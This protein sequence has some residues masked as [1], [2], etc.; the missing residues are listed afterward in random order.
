[1][2]VNTTCLEKEGDKGKNALRAWKKVNMAACKRMGQGKNLHF[3]RVKG[4]D[5]KLLLKGH[6]RPAPL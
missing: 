3:R 5:K 2:E 4:W 1:M 6:I